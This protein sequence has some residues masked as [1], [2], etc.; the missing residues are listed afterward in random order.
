MTAG[1]LPAPSFDSRRP[2]DR[3]NTISR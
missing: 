1:V 2:G 3:R